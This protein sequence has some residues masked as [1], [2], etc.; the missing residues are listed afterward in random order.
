VE[1]VT[2]KPREPI[3][4]TMIE[5]FPFAAITSHSQFEHMIGSATF[6]ETCSMNTGTS[7]S[8][9]QSTMV[10]VQWGLI[11]YPIFLNCNHMSE[12]RGRFEFNIELEKK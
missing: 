10:G 8:L 6:N 5:M 11:R 2:R 4:E 1:E 12:T 7:P 3:I 9:L